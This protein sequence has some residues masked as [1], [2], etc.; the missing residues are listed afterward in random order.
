MTIRTGIQP[1]A[2][3]IVPEH[4]TT[5]T[6]VGYRSIAVAGPCPG[7]KRILQYVSNLHHVTLRKGPPAIAPGDIVYCPWCRACH[8]IGNDLILTKIET[9]TDPETRRQVRRCDLY[10]RE[11]VERTTRPRPVASGPQQAMAGVRIPRQPK[12]TRDHLR[13]DI[14]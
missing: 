1:D 4:V 10:A 8:S 7:C 2:R 11:I 6:G 5:P 14:A 3:G 9:P 13:K 12:P